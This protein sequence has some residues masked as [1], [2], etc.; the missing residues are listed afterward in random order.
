[1][2]TPKTLN[3]IETNDDD[4]DNQLQGA[5]NIFEPSTSASS[6]LLPYQT[7]TSTQCSERPSK[8]SRQLTLFGSKKNIGLT[9]IKINDNNKSLIKMIVFDYQ[10]LSIVENVGFLEYT[11]KLQPL[12]SVPSR[13]QLTTKLL[14][15]EYDNIY[16]KLKSILK[17]ISD[18]SNTTDMWTDCNKSYITVTCHFIFD[19]HLYSPVLATR[20]VFDSHTGLNIA[21]TLKN[22]FNEWGITNKIITIVSDNGSN[23]KNAINEHLL[24]YHHPCVAHTLN[25]S[26]NEAIKGNIDINQI[27]KKCRTIVGHFK[28]SSYAN[29]KL[30]E[31]QLQ[32]NLLILKVKQDIVTRWNSSLIMIERLIDIKTPLSATMSSPP[33]APDYLNASEWEIILDCIHILKPLTTYFKNVPI[34]NTIGEAFKNILI[35]V[36]S[37]RLG[38][39][40]TNKIVAKAT[41]LDPRFK[42]TAFGLLEN[43]N[44]AQKWISDELTTMIIHANNDNDNTEVNIIQS[45]TTASTSNTSNSIGDHFDNKVSQVQSSSSPST[46]S[47]L[48]IRQYLE[49]LLLI[50]FLPKILV[51]FENFIV[52]YTS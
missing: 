36:V 2:S 24:K 14:P 5:Q 51:T 16:S 45:T 9:E 46:T 30:R 23:I 48:I 22:I 13:K 21:T 20:E 15:Q 52:Y 47:T 4:P 40:E 19:N 11:K 50:S 6:S 41:F 38:N 28:H 39:L 8:R 29:G 35:D 43:A 27:L 31:F 37:R 32:M 7:Y 26:I 33:R 10:P 17:T 3:P 12:Y 44:N 25:L 34:E 1:M 49:M 42:K 18:L